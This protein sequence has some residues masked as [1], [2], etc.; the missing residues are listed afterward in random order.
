[1]EEEVH[2]D[3][4]QGLSGLGAAGQHER[5]VVLA[6]SQTQALREGDVT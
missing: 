2:M 5:R 3:E 1:M 4:V 6:V